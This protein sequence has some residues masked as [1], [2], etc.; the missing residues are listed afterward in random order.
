MGKVAHSKVWLAANVSVDKRVDQL[1]CN[2]KITEFDLP[3]SVDENVGGLD[4]SV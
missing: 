3:S 2:A 1:S 4:V